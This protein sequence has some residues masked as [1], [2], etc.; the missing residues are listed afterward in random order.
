[1]KSPFTAAGVVATLLAAA[2]ALTMSLPAAADDDDKVQMQARAAAAGLIT[3]EQAIE[4]ALAAKAG[5][6]VDVDLDDKWIGYVYEIE[7]VDDAGAEW[8]VDVN[9]KTGEVAR[10]KRDLD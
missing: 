5:T 3:A 10:V 7:I 2:T 8:D 6:V 4:K 1:M 9:A